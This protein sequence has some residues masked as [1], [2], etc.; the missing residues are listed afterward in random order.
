MMTFFARARTRLTA[1]ALC[2]SLTA[3]GYGGCT[4]DAPYFIEDVVGLAP[5][6]DYYYEPPVYYVDDVVY[7][8]YYVDVYYDP[9]DYYYDGYD[10]WYY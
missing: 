5:Y 1:L 9:Y 6:Y 10:Y 3:F 8:P 2:A 4:V 7:D